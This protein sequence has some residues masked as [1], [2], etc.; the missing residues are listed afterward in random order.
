MLYRTSHS[1]ELSTYQ[2]SNIRLKQINT[3]IGFWRILLPL[4]FP[5][6]FL[7]LP[8][9]TNPSL[10]GHLV[11]WELC[12]LTLVFPDMLLEICLDPFPAGPC[13]SALSDISLNWPLLGCC[14]FLISFSLFWLDNHL[15]E[16]LCST[17]NIKVALEG[18]E[19][20]ATWH[21]WFTWNSQ[22]SWLY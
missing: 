10:W 11:G 3:R 12:P 14:T 5:L 7:L 2:Y 1:R 13:S 22:A 6:P 19:G 15:H 16:F 8:A 18:R 9:Q 20:A 17:S 21:C 4:S